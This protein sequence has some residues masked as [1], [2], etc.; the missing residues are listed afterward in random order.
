M[1]EAAVF[2]DAFRGLPPISGPDDAYNAQTSLMVSSIN[3]GDHQSGAALA[4]KILSTLSISADEQSE[5]FKS[6][7]LEMLKL[8]VTLREV[9]QAR[10]R[11]DFPAE[12]RLLSH[13]TI[14]DVSRLRVSADGAERSS[15]PTISTAWLEYVAE[16]TAGLPRPSWKPKT[17]A[18]Q[19]ATILEFKEIVGDLPV[20]KLTRDQMLMYRDKVSRLPANRRK[21]YPDKTTAELLEMD[22]SADHLPAART[23]H[24][25]LV[26]IGAFLRWC[27]DTKGYLTSD[28]LAGI[29][30][31]SESQSYAVFTQNDLKLLFNSE[32]YER[33]QHSRSWHFWTPLIGLYTGARQSEIAQLTTRNVI[34]E[35]QVWLLAITDEG[36]GQ[37]VKTRAGIRKVPISSKLVGLGLLDYVAA[38]KNLG[39]KRLFPDLAR[40]K[41]GWGQKV[42]R[43]FNDTYRKQCGIKP[44]P[45]GGR[46]VFH[47]FRHTAITK[48][49]SSSVASLAHFQQVFGHEKSVLGETATYM[50]A[51]PAATLV[52]VIEALDFGLDHSHYKNAWKLYA[53]VRVNK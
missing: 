32:T 29:H 17:T 8:Q 6:L 39:E 45:T 35:D 41:H 4:R 34:E 3:R 13:Y 47:S 42:S 7:S 10:V 51:F 12:Q 24:E 52:P 48:A 36:E 44:D 18:E 38:L 11:G 5:E 50:G 46:K 20:N 19:Q 16:K 49:L 43:W 33:G 40:G 9:A 14:G 26:R 2:Y 31:E 28:P 25:K 23:V 27:R 21:R 15:A 37:H 1:R 53:R 22:I 30:V